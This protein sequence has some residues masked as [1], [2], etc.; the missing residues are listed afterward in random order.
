M[1]LLRLERLAPAVLLCLFDGIPSVVH[2]EEPRQGVQFG[3]TMKPKAGGFE[4]TLRPRDKATFDYLNVPAVPVPFRVGGARASST[5]RTWSGGSP[6]S[7]R[8]AATTGSTRAST[9][10][11]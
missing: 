1:R 2:I 8:P 4:A 10:C 5:S 7:R 6:T 11:S 9:P 3:F